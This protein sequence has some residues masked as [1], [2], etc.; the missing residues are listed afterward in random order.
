VVTLSW[1]S[2]PG[3]MYYNVKRGTVRG[4]LHLVIAEPTGTTFTDS[5]L[6]NGTTY[7]YVVAAVDD[8]G[9]QSLD[10][11]EAVATPAPSLSR[12]PAPNNLTATGGVGEIDLTWDPVGNGVTYKIYRAPTGSGPWNQIGTSP[13]AA[14]TDHLVLFGEVYYYTVS[15]VNG[16]GEGVQSD[17]VSATV[18]SD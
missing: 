5:G 2:V 18:G 12:P 17:P 14:Y 8:T 11:V 15:A 6:T 13:T 16:I 1:P 3:A 4:G 10:S 9:A 7:Y